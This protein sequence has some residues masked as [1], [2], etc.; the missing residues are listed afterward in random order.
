MAKQR[1]AVLD[2]GPTWLTCLVG[3]T[4]DDGQIRITGWGRNPSSGWRNGAVVHP[5]KATQAIIEAWRAATKMANVRP[6]TVYVSVTGE[7]IRSIRGKGSVA[8]QRPHKGISKHDLQAVIRQ[9]RAI[10]LPQDEMILHVVPI[11]YIVDGQKGVTEPRGLFGTKLDAEVHIVIAALAVTE[12]IYRTVESAGLRVR[13]LLLRSMAAALG[14]T[15]LDERNMG[16]ALVHLGALTDI[17]VYREFSVRMNKTMAL[18]GQHI[19]NDIAMVLRIPH[20]LAEKIKIEHGVAMANRV[21]SDEPIDVQVQNNPRQISRRLLASVIEPRVEEILLHADAEIRKSGLTEFLAGGVVL[22][23]GTA[24]MPGIGTLAEQVMNLPVRIGVPVGVLAPDDVLNN[25][26]YV[27]ATGLVR[28]G[29]SGGTDIGNAVI[30]TEEPGPMQ[31]AVE[32][33]IRSVTGRKR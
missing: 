13:S 23:G 33:L 22:T 26:S 17:V 6:D 7:H 19:T 30:Q 27:P 10:A 25:P 24:R 14:G 29:L 20:P 5:E 8:V 12:N 28:F 21:D 4:T 11:Q 9:A 15:E 1:V 31:R 16:V 18:G 3:E 2:P 32:S